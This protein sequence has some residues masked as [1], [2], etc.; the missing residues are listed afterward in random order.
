MKKMAITGGKGGTGKSTVA[1]LM[2]NK[3]VG[4]GKRVV[5]VD[6]DV[7][8]PNDYL[9]LGQRLGAAKRKVFARLPQFDQAKCQKCVG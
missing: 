4:A 3:L 2:A 5:L 7:E 6:A 1:V 8:C 9:L